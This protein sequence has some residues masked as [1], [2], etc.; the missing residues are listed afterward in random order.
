MSVPRYSLTD[1]KPFVIMKP[2]IQQNDAVTA[3][4]MAFMFAGNISPITAQ[5]RGPK[6]KVI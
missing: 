5:G 3:D 4:A 2:S 6:P 1:E